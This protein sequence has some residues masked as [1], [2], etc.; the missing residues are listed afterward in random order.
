[1]PSFDRNELI[2]C[3]KKLVVM[4]KEWI[5]WMGEPEQF[6]TRLMHFSTDKTLGV[7]SPQNTKIVAFINPIQRKV[8]SLTLKCST[9]M[10]KNWPLGH[11]SF[12]ISGNLGPL[13]PAVSDA[14]SNGFDVVL[15]LLDD[16]IKET[17]VLNVFIL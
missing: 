15:W 2:N 8:N 4:D 13:V 14:K 17:T 3:L 7:R 1:M 12:R 16:Y 5:T 6:Y 10:A 11:G 9:N